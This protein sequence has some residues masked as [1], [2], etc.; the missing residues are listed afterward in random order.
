[1]CRSAE[2]RSLLLNALLW[3]HVK[4]RFPLW[5]M[6]PMRRF[7]HLCKDVCERASPVDGESHIPFAHTENPDGLFTVL[8]GPTYSDECT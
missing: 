5:T 1:M 6:T 4:Q 3:H 7:N 8:M 2:S